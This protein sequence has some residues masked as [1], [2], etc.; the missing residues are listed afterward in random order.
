MNAAYYSPPS[1]SRTD[2]AQFKKSVQWQWK[3]YRTSSGVF[4]KLHSTD[5]LIKSIRKYAQVPAHW[6]F[7]LL[8]ETLN[9]SVDTSCKKVFLQETY[10][11]IEEIASKISSTHKNVFDKLG[12]EEIILTRE[13]IVCILANA[14]LCTF[15]NHA[16]NKTMPQINF[17]GLFTSISTNPAV[18]KEKIKCI[19]NYFKLVTE[20][21]F[22]GNLRDDVRF[23]KVSLGGSK[24]GAPQ[25]PFDPSTISLD[26]SKF[27]NIEG[28]L[29]ECPNDS[30]Q[31]MFSNKRLGG[32][33][34]GNGSLQE[35]N[36]FIT[37]PE[38]IVLKIFFPELADDEVV[39]VENAGQFSK[40]EGYGFTF[41]YVPIDRM[42][43]TGSI[44]A[45]DA[46]DFSRH[47]LGD[48]AQWEAENIRRETIKAYV[49]FKNVKEQ[50][51]G[52]GFWG[53]GGFKG[54]PLLK[55]LIQ[56]IAAT[57]ANKTLQLFYLPNER[58]IFDGIKQRLNSHERE[59]IFD[60]VLSKLKRPREKICKCNCGNVLCSKQSRERMK[61]TPKST[62]AA[63]PYNSYNY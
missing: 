29:F 26:L 48:A 61:F 44:I 52:T 57:A 50:N 9:F 42:I 41:K 5:D 2:L 54:D 36:R 39:I 53:C 51:I 22:W 12:D 14:F 27:G 31:V 47:P 6:N 10:K 23:K 34:L 46:M 4:N 19:L 18:Q 11:K 49:G 13:Q 15:P 25:L 28:D 37:C 55:T 59:Q 33:V 21:G 24:S 38:L 60:G 3:G 40:C 62:N 56:W 35:E 63:Y 32:G 7:Q 1:F 58:Y 30:G 45:M 20:Y 8:E 43:K 17:I 16:D